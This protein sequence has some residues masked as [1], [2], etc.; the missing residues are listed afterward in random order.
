MRTILLAAALVVACGPGQ[1][2]ASPT[3]NTSPVLAPISGSALPEVPSPSGPV[4]ALPQGAEEVAMT[5]APVATAAP[6]PTPTPTP[7][8]AVWRFE[9]RVVDPDG[10]PL[11]GVCVVIGPHGCQRG[12]PRTDDRGVYFIDLPQVTTVTYDLYFV[13]EGYLTVWH[14]LQPKEPTIFNVILRRPRS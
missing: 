12:S 14:Q 7:D 6:P 13:R 4:G 5:S 2:T 1:T 9:G 11:P 10:K 8:P 3:P